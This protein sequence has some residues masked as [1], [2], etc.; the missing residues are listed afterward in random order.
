MSPGNLP[1]N[2]ILLQNMT[3][4]PRTIINTPANI[5]NFPSGSKPD[6]SARFPFLTARFW[7]P[8]LTLIIAYSLVVGTTGLFSVIPVDNRAECFSLNPPMVCT[9]F[10]YVRTFQPGYSHRRLLPHLLPRILLCQIS[11]SRFPEPIKS[12]LISHKESLLLLHQ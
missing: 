1:K 5:S 4:R 12:N 6:M 9:T 2:G 10:A 3:N 7:W 11:P 8:D